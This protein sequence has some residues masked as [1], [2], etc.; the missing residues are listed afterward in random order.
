MGVDNY[1]DCMLFKFKIMKKIIKKVLYK[2]AI[3]RVSYRSKINLSRISRLMAKKVVS[4][5]LLPV[6]GIEHPYVTI[7]YLDAIYKNKHFTPSKKYL[8]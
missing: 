4:I 8:K 2:Y 6:I 1:L 3:D 7:S 5:D